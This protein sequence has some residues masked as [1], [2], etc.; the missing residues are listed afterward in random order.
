MQRDGKAGLQ[1]LNLVGGCT[2]ELIGLCLPIILSQVLWINIMLISSSHL[3]SLISRSRV[4]CFWLF[5]Q[6]AEATKALLCFILSCRNPSSHHEHGM[7][8]HCSYQVSTLRWNM[9]RCLYWLWWRFWILSHHGTL[10]NPWWEESS[11][12]LQT[13]HPMLRDTVL[14]GQ[15]LLPDFSYRFIFSCNVWTLCFHLA[16]IEQA[17]RLLLSKSSPFFS[18]DPLSNGPGTIGTASAK[19]LYLWSQRAQQTTWPDLLELAVHR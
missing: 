16:A 10:Q 3:H 2:E 11:E 4:Q 7:V 1:S 15:D 5:K 12:V 9:L 19:S 14:L 17:R 13:V 18:L 8:L 6:Q